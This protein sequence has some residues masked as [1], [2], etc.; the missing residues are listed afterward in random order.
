MHK[1]YD[2]EHD[3][4]TITID[5]VPDK[6]A[7]IGDLGIQISEDGRVWICI[8]GLSFLRF[9]PRKNKTKNKTKNQ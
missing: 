8:D 4:G 7:F 5:N 2:L 1:E 3:E 6:K 9:T